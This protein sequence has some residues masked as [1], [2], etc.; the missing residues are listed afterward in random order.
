MEK[1]LQDAVVS[2]RQ[3][4]VVS[5]LLAALNHRQWIRWEAWVLAGE[6]TLT[7]DGLEGIQGRLQDLEVGA[8]IADQARQVRDVVKQALGDFAYQPKLKVIEE[9][10]LAQLNGWVEYAVTQNQ[11]ALT[12]WQLQCRIPFLR[13]S[14]RAQESDYVEAEK[15]LRV[16]AAA[17]GLVLPD[18]FPEFKPHPERHLRRLR[19]RHALGFHGGYTISERPWE[20]TCTGCHKTL[21][22]A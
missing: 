20:R 9:R 16:V 15:D 13:L 18:E 14:G 10:K 17:G 5:H 8:I 11:D 21:S 2:S 22:Y 12:R 4:R 19:A 1:Y 7:P 6:T 3:L